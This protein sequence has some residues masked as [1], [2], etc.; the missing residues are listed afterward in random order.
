[1]KIIS[2]PHYT[3]G[4]LLC[5]IL[6]NTYSEV[7]T[8]GGIRSIHHSLGKIGDSDSVYTDFDFEKLKQQLLQLSTDQWIGTHCW[9]GHNDLE[10]FDQIINVTTMTYRSRLYRWVRAYHHY[11]LSSAPWQGLSGI[12]EIDKQRETAK[13][14]L[15][16][17]SPIDHARVI[18]LEFADVVESRPVMTQML[19]SD[20]QSHLDRWHRINAFLFDD[21]VWTSVAAQR[22]HEAEHE[23]MLQQRYIYD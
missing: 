19:P 14:Y 22:F 6:N 20:Y 8:N 2:F 16:P 5:D 13:N 12:D 15:L 4:G 18:N 17:F 3:C 11:Y 21:N 7:D 10:G 1:M 9:L 23:E